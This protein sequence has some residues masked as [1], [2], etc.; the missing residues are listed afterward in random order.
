MSVLRR[1]AAVLAS[2]A[3]TAA[4]AHASPLTPSTAVRQAGPTISPLVATPQLTRPDLEA[5]LD[6]F[7]P[8]AL[9][10]ADAAGAVVAVVKD[11]QPL[12]VKGYGYADVDA[13]R[14]MTGDLTVIRPGS[15]S[16]L[17][18]WTAVMQL[19]EQGK[20][21]LDRDV[22]AYLD[23]KL[24]ARP[25]GPITMRRLMTHTPGFEETVGGLLF[26]DPQRLEPLGVTLKRW[27]PQRIFPA[28]STPAYSNYG[29][30]LAGYIVE[31]VSGQPYETYVERNILKPLGMDHST[32]AQPLPKALQPLMSHGYQVASR[33][34]KPFELISTP[35]AGSLSSTGDDM[36]KFMIAHLE[37]ERGAGLLLAPDTARLMHRPAGPALGPLNRM[38]L[39]FFEANLNGR[40]V[41][42]HG[43]DTM[44]FHSELS[45][46]LDDGVGLYFGMNSAGKADASIQVRTA[47]L[48]AFADRY[49]PGPQVQG[50][51]DPASARDHAAALAGVYENS[52]RSQSNFMSALGLVSQMKVIANPDGTVSVPALRGLDGEPRRWREIAPYVWKDVA[53]PWRLAAETRDGRV[54]RF[55]MDQISPIMALEPPPWWRSSAWLT[56]ALLTSLAALILTALLWPVTALARRG[57][58]PMLGL[59]P[60][61]RRAARAA[62]IAAIATVAIVAGWAF[63]LGTGVSD[64]EAFSGRLQPAI[65]AL[66]LA[67]PVV[68]AL[69][70]AA[71]VWNAVRAWR[72]AR[73]AWAARIW[74]LV[75]VFSVVV[76]AWTIV[77]F[78]LTGLNSHF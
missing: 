35:P 69:S 9:E 55:S 13:G 28:G 62:R 44:W 5:W 78:R 15:V 56:P 31:R 43:G 70:L 19:V 26:Y 37:D 33:S 75:L 77:V 58:T 68:V 4:V 54:T 10:R 14:L 61:D 41:I 53:G 51:V 50:A 60:S 1:A 8:Y 48:H 73:P 38:T 49:F 46:F 72:R 25:D 65:A 12:L 42:G 52:R 45:L 59:E 11:G 34:P 71:V 3:A 32:M 36:A 30:A 67:G 20:I 18:T 76:V 66:G 40:R 16:K 22:N 23:F 57:H 17:F 63:V 27:T 24:P 21:D 29:A 39:G 74:S 6:G 47:L 2:L 64:L 7:V